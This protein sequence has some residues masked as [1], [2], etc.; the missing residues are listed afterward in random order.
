MKTPMLI[1]SS[2]LYTPIIFEAFQGEYERSLVACSTA[3]DGNN[4]YLVAIGS[5]EENFTF[6]K[7]YKVFGDP[8]EQTSTCSC[9]LFCR[10]GILRGHA[11]KVLDMMN[12]K[13]LPSQYILK[14]WT[15]RARSGTVQDN[16][17]RNII[18]NP[19]LNEMLCYKYMTRKFLNLALRA[20][21]RPESTLLVN[22]ALDS[23]SKE[24]EEQ[25]NACSDTAVPV[26][27]P[28]TVSPP[29]DLVSTACLKKREVETKSSKRQKSWL[30]KYTS[31]EQETLKKR[32]KKK[33][34]VAA[35][36][37]TPTIQDTAAMINIYPST[38]LPM[39]EMSEPYMAMN[40]FSQTLT[41]TITDDV[42]AEF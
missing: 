19:R 10:I 1:Q 26:T 20:A 27:A 41:G 9:G 25:I 8:L 11:L 22:N 24:V 38:S 33:E 30:D 4:C 18:E 23:L 32:G 37:E 42:I 35:G 5:L 17:G 16:H 3:L 34:K 21:S 31:P 12:I 14:R 15:R 40:T 28:T 36:T 6:E 7:E 13:S 29:N 2:N 39:E